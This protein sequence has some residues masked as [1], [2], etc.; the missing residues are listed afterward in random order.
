MNSHP[1]LI[2]HLVADLERVR[3]LTWRDLVLPLALALMLA[4]M[5]VAIVIGVRSDLVAAMHRP[6]FL[7]ET[8]LLVTVALVGSA[9]LWRVG[10]P[11]RAGRGLRTLGHVLT[12]GLVALALGAVIWSAMAG[13]AGAAVFQHGLLC[14]KGSAAASVPVFVGT[15]IWLR[16]AAPTD[17]GAASLAAGLTS[18][19]LG[20]IAFLLAC[21]QDTP[22]HFGVWHVAMLLTVTVLSRSLLPLVIRW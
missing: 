1:D 18:A 13:S 9:S 19:S 7:V 12:A 8:A 6:F 3:P 21:V 17:L 5:F 16:R 20:S 4:A 22:L 11:G 2:D 10:R 14:Y 15:L